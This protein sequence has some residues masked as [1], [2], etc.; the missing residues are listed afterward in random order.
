MGSRGLRQLFLFL[1]LVSAAVA[2][3]CLKSKEP[4]L[5]AD[6]VRVIQ[7]TGH[8]R[9]ELIK[10]V[11][12]FF[13]S[14]DTA[15]RDALY[16]LIS[17]ME[18]HYAVEYEIMDSAGNARQFDPLQYADYQSMFTAWDSLSALPGGLMY[19]ASRYTLDRDTIRSELLRNTIELAFSSK[20]YPWTNHLPDSI[21][22][23]YVLPY[24]VANED[25]EDWRPLLVRFFSETILSKPY[26]TT[27]K[28]AHSIN[29]LIDSL[30]IS[31]NRLI[32]NA[33]IA[34]PSE[35]MKKRRA[36]PRDL[37]IF[38]VMALR[39]AGIA[40]TL[41]YAPWIS[42][43][44]NSLWF[45]TYFTEQGNWQPLLPREF[46]EKLL[47]DAGRIPKIYRRIYHAVDSSL[48]ALKDLKKTTPPFLGHFH[49]L[50]VTRYY[51]PVRNFSYRGPCPDQLIYLSVY[52]GKSWKPV[53]WAFCHQDSAMF[54]HVGR[55]VNVRFAWLEELGDYHKI[56]LMGSETAA[57]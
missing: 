20:K 45:A 28:V 51:L 3:S 52:N 48:F 40:A 56:N 35:V 8:N 33:N 50:D 19:S 6:V 36:S 44:L 34:L 38:R 7:L 26:T 41:D 57:D 17:N 30:I 39:S 32:K 37:A 1:T 22:L 25:L 54:Y 18:R 21:F 5:P 42:D 31:D 43:S 11:S 29:L 16:F 23:R 49:Y 15:K 55:D 12:W 53:D 10:A 14:D 27:D 2:Q 13:E 46:D 24:R 9:V 47:K 4:G